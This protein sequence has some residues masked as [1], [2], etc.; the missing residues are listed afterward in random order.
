MVN[1]VSSR[2]TLNGFSGRARHFF[3]LFQLAW[4]QQEKEVGKATL[5]V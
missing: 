3:A 5:S 2:G 1:Q 4:A